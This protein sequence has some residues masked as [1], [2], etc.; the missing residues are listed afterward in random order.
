MAVNGTAVDDTNPTV[1][2]FCEYTFNGS[3]YMAHTLKGVKMRDS[4]AC[5]PV[6]AAAPMTF[7]RLTAGPSAVFATTV[8]GMIAYVSLRCL[9]RR[10]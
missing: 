8:E 2:M 1:Y 7:W 6:D 9:L 5:L 10:R 3:D 4:L